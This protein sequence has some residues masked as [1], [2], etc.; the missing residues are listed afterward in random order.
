MRHG[1]L[2]VAGSGCCRSRPDWLVPLYPGLNDAFD[3][4]I[5]VGK[6]S[7]VLAIVKD[8]KRRA[9]MMALAKIIGAI[10]GRPRVRKR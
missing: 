10:S 8:F 9:C 6:I 2:L 1:A 4:I 7:P 5:N 3:N